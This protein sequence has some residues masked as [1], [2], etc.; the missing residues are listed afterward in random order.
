MLWFKKKELIE[1]QKE[2]EKRIAV[3][4]PKYTKQ[5]DK[6]IKKAKEAAREINKV[7]KENHFHFAVAVAAG[8][9]ENK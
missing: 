7:I 2:L 4:I 9:K 6:V 3:E 5:Q 8:Y 1:Q